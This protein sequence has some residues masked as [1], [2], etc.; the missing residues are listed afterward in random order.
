MRRAGIYMAA[1]VEGGEVIWESSE[2]M[3]SVFLYLLER[4]DK[5]R[6]LP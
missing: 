2:K 5:K 4:I 6:A 1:L 3:T